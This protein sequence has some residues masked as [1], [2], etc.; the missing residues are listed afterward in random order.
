MI[1]CHFYSAK[2]LVSFETGW[3]HHKG[4]TVHMFRRTRG[5]RQEE[6]GFCAFSTQFLI[7]GLLRETGLIIKGHA[8]CFNMRTK[9]RK[10]TILCH[11]YSISRKWPLE[12]G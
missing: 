10:A 6:E 1:L 3:P 7:S 8:I 5:Q 2:F 4:T 12:T 9:T 11:F